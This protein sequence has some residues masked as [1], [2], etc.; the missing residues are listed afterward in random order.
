MEN[1]PVDASN[2][3]QIAAEKEPTVQQVFVGK[4]D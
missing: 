4:M 2:L 1:V 3:G